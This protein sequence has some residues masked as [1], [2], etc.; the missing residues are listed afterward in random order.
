MIIYVKVKPNSVKNR[1]EKME[2]GTYLVFTKEKAIEGK[3]NLEVIKILS[4]ELGVSYKNIK[5][6][7]PRSRDK[8]IEI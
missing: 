8:I 3:A 4:K 7:N 5:I 6:K 2:D 1:I